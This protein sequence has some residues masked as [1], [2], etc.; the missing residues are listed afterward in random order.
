MLPRILKLMSLRDG[1]DFHVGDVSSVTLP[2]IVTKSESWRAGG[3]IGEVD[4]DLGIEKLDLEFT[5]GGLAFESFT[6]V[7][8][9]KVDGT[10]YRFAGS[11][12]SGN[13]EA[14]IPVE[15]EAHGR[16]MELDPGEAKVGNLGETKI[17]V[18][19]SYL[20]VDIS[21]ATKVEIDLINAIQIID[22]K[23]MYSEHRKNANMA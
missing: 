19:A 16:Q 18:N 1:N 4:I 2:K 10:I 14:P 11:Y 20:K 22:G 13:G 23:D 17:K 5:I 6:K 7:S 8:S 12:D 3:M 21:S 15:I 9:P